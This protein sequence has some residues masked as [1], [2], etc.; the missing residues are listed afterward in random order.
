MR[1]CKHMPDSDNPASGSGG[2]LDAA[3]PA[4]EG[5]KPER[6]VKDTFGCLGRAA[7]GKFAPGTT[8]AAT[9]L[10]GTLP[11]WDDA[12]IG[13]RIS[14]DIIKRQIAQM[15]L[16]SLYT[17]ELKSGVSPAGFNPEAANY[18]MIE[19]GEAFSKSLIPK[20]LG[21][22]AGAAEERYEKDNRPIGLHL[23]VVFGTKVKSARVDSAEVSGAIRF[24]PNLV[25]LSE[26]DTGELFRGANR[27]MNARPAEALS[28][29]ELRQLAA[30]P[31]MAAQK[32][33]GAESGVVKV[34]DVRFI[35]D[36]YKNSSLTDQQIASYFIAAA[37]DYYQP[38]LSEEDY[39]KLVEVTPVTSYMELLEKS[40]QKTKKEMESAVAQLKAADDRL[41]A[42]DDRLKAADDRLKAV[43]SLAATSVKALLKTGMSRE[44]IAKLLKLTD[45]QLREL[46]Q[47]GE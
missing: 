16:D 27:K 46:E 30:Y 3:P 42:A 4:V 9:G 1:N 15:R 36:C 11:G 40:E 26:L 28:Q 21:C 10:Y 13:T 39:K 37:M 23:T 32:R 17:L 35:V 43:A 33:A 2:G 19:R 44:E 45:G 41:K 38:L 22:M 6:T 31:E 25:L 34:E 12:R 24:T 20:C 8:I 29:L 18:L 47:N 5:G 14:G 7:F